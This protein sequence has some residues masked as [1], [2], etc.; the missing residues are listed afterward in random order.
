MTMPKAMVL[1]IDNM[2]DFE[3]QVLGAQQPVLVDFYSDSCPPCRQLAP[4]IDALAEE[5][6]GCALLCKVNVEHATD[7]AKRYGIQGIPAVVFFSGGQEVERLVRLQPRST[8][9]DALDKLIG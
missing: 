7:L 8:Y 9:T 6:D 1:Q 3:T 2:S 4:A 5:Y